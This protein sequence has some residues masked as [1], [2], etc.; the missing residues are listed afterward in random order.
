[1]AD[2]KLFN[3]DLKREYQECDTWRSKRDALIKKLK[4]QLIIASQ[5][6]QRG[7]HLDV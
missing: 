5:S 3:P 4:P 6:D 2:Y 7:G 1:M